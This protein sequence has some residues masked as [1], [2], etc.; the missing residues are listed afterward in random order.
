MRKLRSSLALNR[1]YFGVVRKGLVSLGLRQPFPTGGAL[2]DATR[3]QVATSLQEARRIRESTQGELILLAGSILHLPVVMAYV[4]RLALAGCKVVLLAENENAQSGENLLAVPGLFAKDAYYKYL[5]LPCPSAM[6]AQVEQLDYLRWA[7]DNLLQRH[8]DMDKSYAI[9]YASTAWDYLRRLFEQLAPC[10]ILLWNQFHAFHH[11]AGEACRQLALP[12]AY[13]EYGVLPGTL[14]LDLAGQMGES[15][16]ARNPQGFAALPISPQ[17]LTQAKRVCDFLYESRLNRNQQPPL[18]SQRIPTGRPVILYAGQNDFE[19]GMIP[20]TQR[21]RDFHSP[22]FGSSHEALLY[23]SQ[24]AQKE[25]WT[26]LFKE[27]PLLTH[28]AHKKRPIPRNV[29]VVDAQDINA[30]VDMSDVVITILSQVGYVSLIRG[31]ATV[32]LG[33]TQLKQSD[34][35]YEAFSLEQV[36]EQLRQAVVHGRTPQQ[37]EAF[38]EHAARLLTYYLFDDANEQHPRYGRGLDEFIGAVQRYV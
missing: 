11:I 1:L 30:L 17:N 34:C 12:L 29:V 4:E 35:S 32:M 36:E 15:E 27:H 38:F 33:Y 25:N 10:R 7:R 23:L 14:C 3:R 16:I 13:L 2:A 24:L 31:K 8:P 6:R 19:S 26:L 9:Y 18:Q 5:P 37:R 28:F 21:S 22:L 20:Y